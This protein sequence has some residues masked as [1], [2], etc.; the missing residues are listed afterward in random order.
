[1]PVKMAIMKKSREQVLELMWR[2][3][4]YGKQYGGFF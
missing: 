2:K 1:M 4:H 3:S